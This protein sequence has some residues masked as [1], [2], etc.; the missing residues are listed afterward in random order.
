MSKPK[1][2]I[3]I[4]EKLYEISL[5]DEGKDARH[6]ELSDDEAAEYYLLTKPDNPD[7]QL[8]NELNDM[9]TEVTDK[10]KASF[11]QSLTNNVLKILGF[12]NRYGSEWEVDHCNNRMSFVGDLVAGEVKKFV[13]EN[14]VSPAMNITEKEKEKLI[15][16]IKV[17][18]LKRCEYEIQNM[19]R[20]QVATQL[21]NLVGKVVAEMI[22]GQ[23]LEIK[24]TVADLIRVKAATARRNR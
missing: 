9:V 11:K 12:N 15:K 6:R 16:A 19:V 5:D 20:T 22:S 3:K 10:M 8:Q 18:Y 21:N 4:N 23:E 1:T 24:K 13:A 17:N 14:A 7:F 2:I